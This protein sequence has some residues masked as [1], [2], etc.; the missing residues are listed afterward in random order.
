MLSLIMSHSTHFIG[1]LFNVINFNRMLVEFF[2]LVVEVTFFGSEDA[3]A[4]L[5]MT[6]DSQSF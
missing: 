1:M 4:L 6:I 3:I 2:S 5:D